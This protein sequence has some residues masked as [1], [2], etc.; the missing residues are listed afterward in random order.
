[1]PHQNHPCA[2]ASNFGVQNQAIGR[3]QQALEGCRTVPLE[4][5]ELPRGGAN[6]DE[7]GRRV[8]CCAASELAPC[9]EPP[10]R[11]PVRCRE[12][13]EHAIVRA[14]DEDVTSKATARE[15]LLLRDR[16]LPRKFAAATLQREDLRQL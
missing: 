13:V 15:D 7:L 3:A 4:D 14:D 5:V 12:C 1:M 2:W 11:R 10:L 8:V 6:E 9:A 16:V